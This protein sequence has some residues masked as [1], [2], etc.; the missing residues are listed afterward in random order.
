MNEQQKELVKKWVDA[1]RSGKYKQDTCQ[2]K[3]DNGYCC[4]GVAVEV[5]P[6]WKFST[7][8]RRYINDEEKLIG[9][10]NEYPSTE[11]LQDFGVPIKLARRLIQMNDIDDLP[12]KLIA[13]YVEKEL[14]NDEQEVL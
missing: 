2:L 9:V 12:F 11:M 13:D 1:L 3:T 14:L 8:K 4:M 5:H 10:E 7:V 6:E